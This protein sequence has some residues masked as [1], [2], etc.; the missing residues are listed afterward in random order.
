MHHCDTQCLHL[1][2]DNI[3][4]PRPTL[5]N[6]KDKPPWIKDD[7]FG[8]YLPVT[9][10]E[11]IPSRT[12]PLNHRVSSM[13]QVKRGPGKRHSRLPGRLTVFWL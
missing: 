9:I 5:C 13:L 11:F 1:D 3:F 6:S 10:G 8:P 2:S 7:S 4:V 12:H